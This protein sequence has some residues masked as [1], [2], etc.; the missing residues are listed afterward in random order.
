M[1]PTCT[2]PPSRPDGLQIMKLDLN[3]PRGAMIKE[4]RI[5]TVSGHY[6]VDLKAKEAE[7][8][9]ANVRHPISPH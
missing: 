8:M 7:R 2:D 9:S 6:N 5:M 3:N 4:Q 1:P